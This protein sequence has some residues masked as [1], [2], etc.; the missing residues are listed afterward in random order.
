MTTFRLAPLLLLNI[1]AVAP[2]VAAKS[3][4]VLP[5]TGEGVD[6]VTLGIITTTIEEQLPKLGYEAVP[7]GT[8]ATAASQKCTSAGCTD[9]ADAIAVGKAVGAYRVIS[10]SLAKEGDEVVIRMLAFDPAAGTNEQA[11]A[12]APPSAVLSKV[13]KLLTLV[14]PQ[15]EPPAPPVPEP[16]PAPPA[17]PVEAEPPPSPPPG[18]GET[19]A[20]IPPG[21]GIEPPAGEEASPAEEGGEEPEASPEKKKKERP[22]Q[23][24]RLELSISATMYAM[25]MTFTIMY[26]AGVEGD[27]WYLYPPFMLLAGGTTLTAALLITWKLKV[28]SGDA[29]MFDACLGW[30]MSNGTLIPLAAGYMDAKPVLVGSI[31]G[32]AAGLVGGALAVAFS[33]PSRG[34]AALVSTFAN[35]GSMLALGLAWLAMPD[36]PGRLE[37]WMIAG[38]VGMDAGL[39]A[40]I[41]A[42]VFLEVSPNRLGFINLAGLLGGLV[43]ATVGLPIVLAP[44]HLEDK[45][46]KGYGAMVLSFSVLGLALGAVLTRKLDERGAGESALS[47]LPYLVAHEERGWK[48]GV[49]AIMPVSTPAGGTAL[50]AELAIVGGV[51]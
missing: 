33:D 31:I 27:R 41:P 23:S 2:A 20:P 17:P 32:G 4:A 39:V 47:P 21:G 7:S 42:A 10:V 51:F 8:V 3:A 45:H 22:D 15:E 9:P 14:L 16:P 12:K 40:G 44:K 28:T 37:H 46:W 18:E 43:G 13:A 30:G 1:L 25:I 35:W 36:L 49:P 29:A 19:K 5:A 38:I 26:A 50:G 24:G 34:D 6:A 11:A 48:L